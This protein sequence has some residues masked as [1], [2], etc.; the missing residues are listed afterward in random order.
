MD[1]IHS[2]TE[3]QS[4]IEINHKIVMTGF[5]TFLFSKVI[6]RKIEAGLPKA[7]EGLIEVAEKNG[8][9]HAKD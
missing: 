3:T 7:V 6:G 5:M 1:F 8:T 2:M 9:H 4:G